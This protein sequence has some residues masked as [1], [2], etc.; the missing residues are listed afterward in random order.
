MTP[1][2]K[3]QLNVWVFTIRYASAMKT[4]SDI[5]NKSKSISKGHWLLIK[6]NNTNSNNINH[7]NKMITYLNNNMLWL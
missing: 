4:E 7:Y 6:N 3:F 2:A 5:D 1:W